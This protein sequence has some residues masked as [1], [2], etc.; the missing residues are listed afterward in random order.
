[1]RRYSRI[2]LVL[3]LFAFAAPLWAATATTTMTVSG[4]VVPT[5][6]VAA[7]AL[8]FGAAI[9]NPINSNV[10][11]QGSVTATC[12]TGAAYTVALSVGNGAGATFA[13]RKMTSGGNTL[14]YSLY[15]DASRTTVWGDGTAGSN[16]FGGSGSGAAQVIPVYGR[17]PSP[18]TVPTGAYTDTV[19]VTLT[20]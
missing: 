20:F 19:V 10:D 12:S 9:P 16:T 7:A 3:G 5:C 6:S 15:T 11:A 14:N 18:Q 1:M 4:T 2:L 17:I 13:S 8:N